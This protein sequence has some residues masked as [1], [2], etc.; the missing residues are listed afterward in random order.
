MVPFSESVNRWSVWNIRS[1]CD[2][3]SGYFSVTTRTSPLRSHLAE[4]SRVEPGFIRTPMNTFVGHTRSRTV[5]RAQRAVHRQGHGVAECTSA[6]PR[7]DDRHIVARERDLQCNRGIQLDLG[8]PLRKHLPFAIDA[9]G[10]QRPA[11]EDEDRRRDH[12]HSDL[13]IMMSVR[14]S[15]VGQVS[16]SCSVL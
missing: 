7:L 13:F 9:C 3:R 5:W 1:P 14:S 4:S 16:W 10:I 8:A 12:R 2:T 15:Q 6:S 11:A